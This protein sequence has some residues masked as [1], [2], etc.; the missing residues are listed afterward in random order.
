MSDSGLCPESQCYEPAQL[1]RIAEALGLETLT[2]EFVHRLDRAALQYEFMAMYEGFKRHGDES[3][4][5]NRAEKRQALRRVADAALK[6]KVAL[7]DRAFLA[8]VEFSQ[9]QI[10]DPTKL[11]AFATAAR[12]AADQL[13]KDRRIARKLF[14]EELAE[15]FREVTGKKPTLT[16]SD[17]T[18]RYSGPF[19]DFVTAS[20]DP[21]RPKALAGIHHVIREIIADF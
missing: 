11:E 4:L 2:G 1:Q 5:P 6:L 15:M 21:V 3:I 9:R 8:S 12:V 14:V 7:E 10:I 17:Y 19:L 13:P 18:G 16:Y 20:I